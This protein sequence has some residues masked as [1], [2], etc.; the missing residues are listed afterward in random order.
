MPVI[1]INPNNS[2]KLIYSNE[3]TNSSGIPYV[4][5]GIPPAQLDYLAGLIQSLRSTCQDSWYVR[6]GI[7][8]YP[9]FIDKRPVQTYINRI[10]MFYRPYFQNL[11]I[12]NIEVFETE[13][14]Y[15]MYVFYI[16]CFL[17]LSQQLTL[18]TG[19]AKS[20]LEDSPKFVNVKM[21]ASK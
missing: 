11:Y 16:K 17:N 21:E 1:L 3:L 2:Q 15:E 4:D 12:D 6:M 20:T 9:V 18:A 13:N 14:T 19:I 8:F 10:I 7:P 5:L